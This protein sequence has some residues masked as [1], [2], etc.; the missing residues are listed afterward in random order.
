MVAAV[1]LEFNPCAHFRLNSCIQHR[2]CN[3]PTKFG[4][5]R[6]ITNINCKSCSQFKMAAAAILTFGEFAFLDN[7]VRSISD[8]QQ[9]GARWF[10]SEEMA[11]YFRNSR[12]RQPPSWIL[13]N[14]HFWYGSCVLWQI[15]NISTNLGEDWSNSKEMATPFRNS[16]WRRT[17]S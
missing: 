11:T 7:T 6:P 15:L 3:I 13:V 2:I 5:N 17:P 8:S 14:V 12:W 16:K 9:F 10:N 4:Q 1:I